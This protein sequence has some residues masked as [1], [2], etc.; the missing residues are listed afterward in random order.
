[1]NGPKPVWMLA[2]N[3]LNQ[4][5]PRSAAATGWDSVGSLRPPEAAGSFLCFAGVCGI[6]RRCGR[7]WHEHSRTGRVLV[8]R[9][10]LQLLS[11]HTEH[12]SL[13]PGIGIEAQQRPID[14]DAPGAHT[15]KASEIDDRHSNAAFGVREYVDDA[16][17]IL[18]LG[19]CYLLAQNRSEGRAELTD[20]RVD[21]GVRVGLR[22]ARRLRALRLFGVLPALAMR[23]R[24][25]R[26]ARR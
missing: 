25:H 23:L 16:A 5:S 18:S 14:G 3:R 26:D 21:H 11:G 9:R 4:S 2:T 15:E 24:R 6:L 12:E 20:L 8:F 10:G 19:A 13:V 1:M 22:R 17:E 7:R